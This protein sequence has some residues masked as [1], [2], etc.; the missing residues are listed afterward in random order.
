MDAPLT[1]DECL[2]ILDRFKNWNHG[3]KSWSLALRGV[4]TEED[5]ILDARR[6]LIKAATSRLAD[7][8]SPGCVSQGA[9]R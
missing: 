7:M 2:Q 6:R 3:Q 5:D 9:Y 8:A 1:K 4:R